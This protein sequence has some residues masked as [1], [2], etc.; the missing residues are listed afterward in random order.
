[1]F[2]VTV[3][4][5]IAKLKFDVAVLQNDKYKHKTFSNNPQGFQ[6]FIDWLM[7]LL[8][9][10]S[11]DNLLICMESTGSYSFP[12]AEFLT[13]H[14]FNVSVVNPARVHALAKTQLSRTKTDKADAKLIAR[15]A[16]LFQ[17]AVW[18]P[19]PQEIRVLHALIHRAEQLQELLQMERNRLE[20]ADESIKTSLNQIIQTLESELKSV[21]TQIKT[22][23]LTSPHLKNRYELLTSIPGIAE[24]SAAYLLVF[25]SEH[26]HFSNAKQ[27]VA[28]V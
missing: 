3:G 15:Y 18:T 25:L 20:V 2:S 7:V 1:M 8:T 13:A 6:L 26:H 21:R 12:L 27:V 4:I 17:P 19:P 23:I 22:L 16:L 24:I 10:V 14:Q 11:Q 28:F 5:D 9:F